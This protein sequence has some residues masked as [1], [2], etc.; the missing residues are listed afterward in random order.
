[1]VYLNPQSLGT[2]NA[3]QILDPQYQAI[4]LDSNFGS[5]SN[6]IC[7]QNNNSCI[8]Y[9]SPT[10]TIYIPSPYNNQISGTYAF[11]NTDQTNI[12]TLYYNNQPNPFAKIHFI[13]KPIVQH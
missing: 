5:F 10:G 6:G 8:A 13:A 11:D 3:I 9:I 7:I 4:T 1:M 2:S 12:Y